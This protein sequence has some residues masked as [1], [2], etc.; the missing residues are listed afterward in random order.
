MFLNKYLIDLIFYNIMQDRFF[1]AI[2]YPLTNV[3][4][5]YFLP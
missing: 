2:N 1:L 5:G 4:I 3:Q